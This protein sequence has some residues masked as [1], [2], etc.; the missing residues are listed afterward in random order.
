MNPVREAAV[1]V[2]KMAG[3]VAAGGAVVVGFF[4]FT[5]ANAYEMGRLKLL[6]Q[7]PGEDALEHVQRFRD[8]D[9]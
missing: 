4:A 9:L 8:E 5:F 1:S 6:N 7:D 3:A 2:V